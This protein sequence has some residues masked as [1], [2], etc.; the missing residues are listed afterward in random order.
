MPMLKN[1]LG[2]KGE[3]VYQEAN[4]KDVQVITTKTPTCRWTPPHYGP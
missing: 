2:Q 1:A 4:F 3:D